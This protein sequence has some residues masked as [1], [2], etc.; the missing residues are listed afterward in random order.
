M[1]DKVDAIDY[2]YY[3]E[4]NIPRVKLTD[5]FLSDIRKS[6]PELP[7]SRMNKYILLGV[8]K[9]EAKTLVR[10]K[11]ISDYLKKC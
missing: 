11:S 5:E 1:R 10:D 2:K 8:N 7:I 3:V 4:P 9:K 6:I